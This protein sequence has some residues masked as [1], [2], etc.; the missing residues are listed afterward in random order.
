MVNRSKVMAAVLAATC[1]TSWVA[2]AGDGGGAAGADPG[3]A[4]SNDIELG[5]LGLGGTNPD[6]AGRYNGL[7]TKG[8]DLLGQ[9]DFERR[10]SADSTWFYEFT[11]RNLVFQTGSFLGSAVGSGARSGADYRSQTSNNLANLGS[12]DLEFGRQGTW[13]S[14]LGFNSISYTGNVID[15]I[16]S[17]NGSSLATLNSRLTPWGGA[18]AGTA[19]SVTKKTLTIPAL[20]A[21][22]AMQPFQAGTRR[23]IGTG[24]FKYIHGNWSFTGAIRYEHKYGT[25]ENSFDGPWGGTVFAMPIDYDTGRY[26]FTAE[27]AT[28]QDQVLLQ[29]TYSHFEDANTYINLPYPYSN[30]SVPYQLSAAYSTPPSNVADYVTLEAGSN[31]IPKTR[32]SLNARVGLEMQDSAFAPNT[33]DPDPSSLKGYSNLNPVTLQG[34]TAGSPD[35][36]ARVYEGTISATSSPFANS[37]LRAY[38]GIDGRNVT[39]NQFLVYTGGQTNDARLTGS[40]YVI[41]QN[42]VKQNA[43]L[44]LGYLLIPRYSTRLTLGYRYD[45]T[46]RSNAQVGQS[47]TDTMTL[48][49]TSALGSKSF[50]RLSFVH[51]DRSGVLVYLLPWY[52]LEQGAVPS[53]IP[54][55]A[56]GDLSECSGATFEAPMNSNSVKL[57]VD[58]MPRTD[59]TADLLFMYGHR[60]YTYAAAETLTGTGEGLRSSYDLSAGPD[61]TYRPVRGMS[62]HL[63][64]TFERVFYETRGN[65]ACAQSNTGD[66]AGSIGYFQDRYTSDVQTVGFDGKWRVTDK[67][68]LGAH[69]TFAYGAVLY[70]LNNGVLVGTPKPGSFYQ[71]V[72]DFPQIIS[73][74]HDARLTANYAVRANAALLLALGW[75]YYRDDNFNDTA[76]AIQGSG[77]PNISFLT[78]GYGSP[79]YS[80]GYVMIGGRVRF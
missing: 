32:V 69:Y 31:R 64:Y 37:S 26:D 5:I 51:G 73:R 61:V 38:Y 18:S 49:L 21:T 46:G 55:C 57:M 17:A 30:T 56:S 27:Y 23:D 44:E 43:G 47:S 25:L 13:E 40:G 33:A 70:G 3:G 53:P 72:A 41:P 63:Y 62:Y 34:T 67:L 4:Y 77:S 29:E 45:H 71:N 66:C 35:I 10:P 8:A 54:A 9:F 65:G 7:T 20:T 24:A 36:R 50:A 6:Q 28:R 48:A 52:N 14:H 42:W 79:Y 78:P 80:V 68:K 2:Y 76:A 39:L 22:G 75:E 15:S 16:Y 74:M 11:G 59:L 19:G 1:L 58:Y 60:S 12:V